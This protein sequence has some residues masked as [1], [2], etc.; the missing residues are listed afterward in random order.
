MIVLTAHILWLLY[1]TIVLK[2]AQL[3]IR[4]YY[5]IHVKKV[6]KWMIQIYVKHVWIIV[7]AVKITY[8]LN[9]HHHGI[10][11][12]ATYVYK[13]AVTETSLTMI[14]V[15]VKNAMMPLYVPHAQELNNLNAVHAS[16]AI[17]PRM[18]ATN[19]MINAKLVQGLLI[20][21][22][23]H[24]SQVIFCMRVQVVCQSVLKIH[25]KMR[26]IIYVRHVRLVVRYVIR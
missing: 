17:T 10:L 15:N 8:A 24:V 20:Q 1:V 14:L 11:I 23:N 16:M 2:G 18:V 6:M 12:Q 7:K 5:V 3:V 21:N 26:K 22:V 13:I 4:Q 9:V 25:L 19:V